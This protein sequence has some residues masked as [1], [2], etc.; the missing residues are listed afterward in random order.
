MHV[1]GG[2]KLRFLKFIYK[3]TTTIQ[4]FFIFGTLRTTESNLDYIWY[5]P[6]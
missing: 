2:R 3:L 6:L 4:H 1:V 5:L